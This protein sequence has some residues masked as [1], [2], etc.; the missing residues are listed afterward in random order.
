MTVHG[1]TNKTRSAPIYWVSM[2]PATLRSRLP[3]S[4]YPLAP[5]L[6]GNFFSI[7]YQLVAKGD[8]V[9]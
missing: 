7:S 3:V 1:T 2:S 4:A 9:G 5:F 8:D 6:T